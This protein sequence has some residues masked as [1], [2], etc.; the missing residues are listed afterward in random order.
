MNNGVIIRRGENGEY[1]V[2][3]SDPVVPVESSFYFDKT[4]EASKCIEVLI[5]SSYEASVGPKLAYLNTVENLTGL[6]SFRF[7]PSGGSLPIPDPVMRELQMLD[8]TIR[9]G[10]TA[11]WS[12]LTK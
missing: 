5:H 6:V 7:S 1:V 2:Q 10:P 3:G 8:R 11:M 4:Q 12:R 9:Q